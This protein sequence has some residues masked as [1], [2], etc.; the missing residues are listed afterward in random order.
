MRNGQACPHTGVMPLQTLYGDP[1]APSQIAHVSTCTSK[2]VCVCAC[3]CACVCVCARPDMVGHCV[4]VPASHGEEQAAL[5][6]CAA[7]Q[8]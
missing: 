3:V 4:S 6:S 7:L 5:Q 1:A 2:C 8:L